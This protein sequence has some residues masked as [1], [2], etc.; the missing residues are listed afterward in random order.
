MASSLVEMERA[1]VEVSHL[2]IVPFCQLNEFA[3]PID[4]PPKNQEP[5]HEGLPTHLPFP[6]RLSLGQSVLYAP[7]VDPSVVDS[8]GLWLDSLV[9]RSYDMFLVQRLC[10]ELK[11]KFRETAHDLDIDRVPYY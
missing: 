3:E 6:V 4:Y 10:L 1:L 7:I 11:R 8:Y 9:Q 5:L 2:R